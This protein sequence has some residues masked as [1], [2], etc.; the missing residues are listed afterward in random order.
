MLLFIEILDTTSAMRVIYCI[1]ICMCMYVYINYN[2]LFLS[3][4]VKLLTF[5]ILNESLDTPNIMQIETT[6]QHWGK[7][8]TMIVIY[9]RFNFFKEGL[10]INFL[11]LLLCLILWLNLKNSR[12]LLTII[13]VIL[14]TFSILDFDEQLFFLNR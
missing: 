14:T 6:N 1:Y 3:T 9:S 13:H 2:F 12:K 4:I 8:T 10:L 7:E 11:I 5:A